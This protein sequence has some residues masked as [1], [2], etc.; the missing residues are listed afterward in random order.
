DMLPRDK[1]WLILP[2]KRWLEWTL[3]KPERLNSECH[4][5]NTT[6]LKDRLGAA[7]DSGENAIMFVALGTSPSDERFLEEQQRYILVDDQ[8]PTTTC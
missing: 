4:L 1:Q 6:T 3:S 5:V 8:W 2:R 7:Q